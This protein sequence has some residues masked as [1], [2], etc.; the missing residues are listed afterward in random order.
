MAEPVDPHG[1]PQNLWNPDL[2]PTDASKRNWRWYHFAALWVGMVISIPAWLLA[3]GLIDQGMSPLQAVIT[4]LLGNVII[5]APMLLIGHAGA[6][7]G[8]PYA[9]LVRSSFGTRGALV[10]ALLR[11]GIACGWYGIQTWVGGQTI[12]TLAALAVPSLLTHEKLG[13]LGISLPH[14]VAFLVFWAIQLLFVTKG[15]TTI[16][17]LETWTAPLKIVICAALMIWALD[18]AGGLAAA[19]EQKSAFVPG[20][21]KEGLFWAVFWPGLTAMIGFWATLALNIPDF[22]RFAATQKDQSIGQTIGLPVPMGLLALVAVV[23]TSATVIV[24]G[25]AIWDPVQLSSRMGG[26]AVLIGLLVIS[27][28]TVSCN[29]AAN[30]VGPAFD[31]SALWPR[32]ISYRTGAFITAL[33]ALLIMPWKLIESSQ[34][35]IFTWLIGYG[36]LLGPI[37]GIMVSDYWLLRQARLTVADLYD[38]N[39]RYRFRAGW[40]PVAFAALILGVAP[41]VPGFLAAAMPGMFG[42]IPPFWTAVYP[43]AWFVGAAIAAAFYTVGMRQSSVPLEPAL[44]ASF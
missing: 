21:S 7:F 14:F 15:L 17:K 19:T 12:L 20:G 10:P 33:I 16:R 4:V 8:I 22:T 32:R 6:K 34:G 40:N 43:Y 27:I 13:F 9:V 41:N 11:A 44:R 31:V 18:A 42:G 1:D 29:I 25:E 24:Y 39:G 35:Y 30:L 26:I 28:D 36:A 38:R 37:A 5:L 23:T 3:G 2:A